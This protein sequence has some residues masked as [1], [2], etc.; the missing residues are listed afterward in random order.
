MFHATLLIIYAMY[1]YNTS[2][3]SLEG[4]LINKLRNPTIWG[5]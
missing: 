1:A 4:D 5:R 3:D 2:V